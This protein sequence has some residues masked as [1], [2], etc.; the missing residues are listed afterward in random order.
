MTWQSDMESLN[1]QMQGINSF[2]KTR[3][4]LLNL[5]IW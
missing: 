4:N 5:S 3:N 1:F 2:D